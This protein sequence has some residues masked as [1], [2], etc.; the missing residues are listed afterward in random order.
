MKEL[1]IGRQPILDRNRRISGYELFFRD[2]DTSFAN[3]KDPSRATAKVIMQFLIDIGI[4]NLVGRKPAFI[5]VNEETIKSE[6]LELLPPEKTVL[7]IPRIMSFQNLMDDLERLKKKGFTLAIDDFILDSALLSFASKVQYVKID[8][9][10][11]KKDALKN[12]F[13]PLK[14]LSV[15]IVAEKV[16]KEKEFKYLYELGFDMFQ[17]YFFAEPITIRKKHISPEKLA[18]LQILNAIELD[19]ETRVIESFFR[20]NPGLTYKLL[21]YINS[22]FFY[23]QHRVRSISHAI[24]LLGYKNL[25][26]WVILLLF[27]VEDEDPIE[28]PLF[29]RAFVR[30]SM[31]EELSRKFSLDRL[32]QDSA[33][34][35]GSL[36]IIDVLLGMPMAEILRS[37]SLSREIEDALLFEMGE[38]GILLKIVKAHETG[39]YD[40][41]EHF[42]SQFHIETN[43][44]LSSEME[45]IL[46]FHNMEHNMTNDDLQA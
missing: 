14:P 10:D 7:E 34:I 31:M 24:S 43:D 22:A 8:I 30:G 28:N 21:R 41:V 44:L 29:E 2:R 39:S 3:I 33:F 12:T 26:R 4:E 9:K 5:N 45:A 15:K 40:H 25:R 19:K 42:L 27:A 37:L 20:R 1:F 38:L 23:I 11:Q 46:N 13:L 6:F 35:T 16:E 18:L 36:S 32:L 17:G